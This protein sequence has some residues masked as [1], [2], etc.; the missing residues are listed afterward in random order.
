MTEKLGSV[1]EGEHSFR[2]W[3]NQRKPILTEAKVPLWLRKHQ[4]HPI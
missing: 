2:T 3:R 1:L 4:Y